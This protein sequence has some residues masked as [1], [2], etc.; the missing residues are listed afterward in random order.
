MS[1]L[2]DLLPGLAPRIGTTP[3]LAGLIGGTDPTNVVE[4]VVEP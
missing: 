4:A 2:L 3:R 1:R